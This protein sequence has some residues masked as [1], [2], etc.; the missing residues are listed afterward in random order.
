M[1]VAAWRRHCLTFL[2]STLKEMG[3]SS[4]TDPWQKPSSRNGLKNLELEDASFPKSS[5]RKASMYRTP[6]VLPLPGLGEMKFLAA[7]IDKMPP[8]VFDN[9]AMGLVLRVMWKDHI[10]FFFLA[11]VFLFLVLYALWIVYVD[12]TASTADSSSGMSPSENIIALALLAVN[13]LFGLKEIIQ[14]DMFRRL[15]YFKSPWNFVDL[16]SIALVYAYIFASFAGGGASSRLVPLVVFAT[17][18]L[19]LKLL[20]YLRGFGDTG[21]L[22]PTPHPAFSI[23]F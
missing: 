1:D 23:L 21:T 20:A 14:S 22:S 17:L 5:G 18:F 15:S 10:R 8:S 16:L 4:Y 3:S 7:L 13:S 12:W 19:T 9:D 11:D 2:L 6:A